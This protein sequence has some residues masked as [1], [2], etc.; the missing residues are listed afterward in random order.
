[1]TKEDRIELSIFQLGTIVELKVEI[2]A[3]KPGTKGF[4]YECYQNGGISIITQNGV[5]L[6]GFA[7]SEQMFMLKYYTDTGKVYHFKNVTQLAADFRRGV[8]KEFFELPKY[9]RERDKQ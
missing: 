7:V 3:E 5:D 8:F 9:K 1:M 6:G 4:V 2:L